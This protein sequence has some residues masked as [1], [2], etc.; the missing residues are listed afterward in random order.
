LESLSTGELKQVIEETNRVKCCYEQH[1]VYLTAAQEE[2]RQRWREEMARR[3]LLEGAKARSHTHGKQQ[4]EIGYQK[5][6]R[7]KEKQNDG[8]FRRMKTVEQRL[9]LTW[10]EFLLAHSGST[11][12]QQTGTLGKPLQLFKARCLG[13]GG[14]LG[15]VWM[16]YQMEEGRPLY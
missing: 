15:Y 11:Y 12:V 16:Q 14:K 8:G 4:E 9:H 1:K 10:R 6:R 3:V 5:T 2:E 7:N 13:K